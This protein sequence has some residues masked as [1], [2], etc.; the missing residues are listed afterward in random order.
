[1][2]GFEVSP[3]GL[4]F[5]AQLPTPALS[6]EVLPT[7]GD[8]EL[9]NFL[10][11]WI[12]EGIPFAF[13]ECPFVYEHLRSWIGYRLD[14]EPRNI[15]VIGSA[16]L[17]WSLARGNSFGK[18]YAADSDLDF[19]VVSERLFA[20]VTAD[21]ELWSSKIKRGEEKCA[22]SYGPENLE[23]LPSN[24]S[25]GFID[26]YKIDHHKYLQYASLVTNTASYARQKLQS[27]TYGPIVSK[28]SIRVFADFDAFFRQMKI[29]LDTALSSL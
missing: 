19:A 12:S 4:R 3:G 9:L 7:L 14:V 29:N 28:V 6:R 13:R 10:R 11:Q 2:R 16:R 21:F 5:T 27:T 23:L 22:N 17:G 18:P 20:N 24:I 8:D 26:P 15:T 1:M 25:R